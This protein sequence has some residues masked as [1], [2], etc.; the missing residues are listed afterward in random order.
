MSAGVT[1]GRVVGRG[2]LAAVALA[3]VALSLTWLNQVA[4]AVM[5]VGGSCASGGAYEV[6]TPC[7]EGVWMAPVSIFLGLAALLAYGLTRP[8]GGPFLLV[9]AWPALF[10]SLGVQFI[11]AAI[12]DPNAFGFWLCGVVFLGMGLAPVIYVLLGER[13]QIV[14]ALVGDGYGEP[15]RGTAPFAPHPVDGVPVTFTMVTGTLNGN[16]N[17]NGH[18][19]GNGNGNGH[20]GD[21]AESLDRLSRLHRAGDLSDAEFADAKQQVLDGA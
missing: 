16:G 1:I 9:F 10:A 20:D 11:R 18:G 6:A 13:R 15:E 14:E 5:D 21:L 19:T 2:A 12:D 8:R 17:G 3:V 4:A 7:P